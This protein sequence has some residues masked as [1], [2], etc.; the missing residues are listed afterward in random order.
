MLLIGICTVCWQFWCVQSK[1]TKSFAEMI[2][3]LNDFGKYN[4]MLLEALHEFR[5]KMVHCIS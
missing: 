3:A 1:M 5:Y 4:V 2:H